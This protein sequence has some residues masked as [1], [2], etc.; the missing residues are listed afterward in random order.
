M[1]TLFFILSLLISISACSLQSSGTLYEKLGEESGISAIVED[2]IGLIGED[3]Q[4]FHFFAET[5]VSRFRNKLIEHLCFISDGPC[6]YTGDNMEDV[7]TG[8]HISEADFNRMVELLQQAM[9][10][11]QV[12]LPT[13]NLLLARL[14]PMRHQIVHI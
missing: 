14:A 8:M 4:L 12:P 11:N 2:L 5:K 6:V 3:K 9:T 1:K 7:H 13:Q 10:T